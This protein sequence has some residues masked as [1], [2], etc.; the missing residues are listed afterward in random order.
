LR[1][2]LSFFGPVARGQIDP[3]RAIKIDAANDR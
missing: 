1:K 2:Q 3:K